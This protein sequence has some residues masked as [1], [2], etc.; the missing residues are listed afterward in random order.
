SLGNSGPNQFD[1]GNTSPSDQEPNGQIQSAPTQSAQVRGE[2]NPAPVAQIPAENQP[3]GVSP[4]NGSGLSSP[5]ASQ[6]QPLSS[7]PLNALAPSMRTP[8]PPAPQSHPQ[9]HPT[10]VATSARIPRSLQS[11]SAA[12]TPAAGGTKPPEAALP[13]IGPVDL[14]E[15]TARS[16]LAQQVKP[17]YPESARASRQ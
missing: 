15:A 2:E 1:P 8:T 4:G 11:Q 17:T 10:T 12:M 13:S 14:P 6:P 9:G 16:L 5:V 3:V 7:N